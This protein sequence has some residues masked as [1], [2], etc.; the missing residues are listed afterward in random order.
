MSNTA[1]QKKQTIWTRPYICALLAN[2]LLCFSQQT[3]GA[4]MT[5]YA[6]YLGAGAMITGL[7]TGLYF[8]VA[9]AARPFSGPVITKCD[10]RKIMIYTYILG[11]ITSIGYAFCQNI[12][13]FIAVRVLHGIEFAFVGSL[14]LTIVGDSLPSDKMGFGVG[15]IGVGIS[16]ASALGPNLG[17]VVREWANA[18]WGESVGY[19]I[20]FSLSALLMIVAIIPAFLLPKL[21]PSQEVLDSL[22]P[23]YKNIACK[24]AII[25]AV[26]SCFSSISCMLF[27]SYLVPYAAE[28]GIEN[29]GLYFTVYAIALLATRPFCGKLIDVLGLGKI[30][31]PACIIYCF[32]FVL[33]AFAPGLWMLLIAAI[34]AAISYGVVSPATMALTVRC[35]APEK[36]G[37]ASNTGYFGMDLG[38]FL[39]PT[40]GGIVY[41]WSSYST[42]YLVVGIVPM[43]LCVAAFALTWGKMKDHLS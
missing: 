31:I 14:S 11:F 20:V 24:E 8:A 22:G 21:K 35:C 30:F 2:S 4:L 16:L 17:I 3:V 38:N 15:M 28:K 18:N 1:K 40:I 7:V 36:R 9:V 19:T 27:S 10:K 29:V 37:V 23:W 13:L 43:L 34:V 5:T 42:M 39:S 33:V 6:R 25:P 41:A 32:A 12:A 26:L